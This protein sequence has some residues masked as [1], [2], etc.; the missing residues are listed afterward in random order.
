METPRG[1]SRDTLI[2]RRNAMRS[3]IVASSLPEPE[4]ISLTVGYPTP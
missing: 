1:D 2:G 3:N 4:N